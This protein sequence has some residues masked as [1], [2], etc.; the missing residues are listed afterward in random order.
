MH[1]CSRCNALD[2][3]GSKREPVLSCDR[4][5][6]SRARSAVLRKQLSVLSVPASSGTGDGVALSRWHAAAA[7]SRSRTR[8]VV[9]S[10][11]RRT[12]GLQRTLSR[13]DNHWS[14]LSR[15]CNERLDLIRAAGHDSNLVASAVEFTI[16][17][18]LHL[19][20]EAVLRPAEDAASRLELV[21][22]VGQQT[23]A[24]PATVP[25][26]PRRVARRPN[27]STRVAPRRATVARAG[28][29]AGHVVHSGHQNLSPSRAPTVT[30]SYIPHPGVRRASSRSTRWTHRC[31]Y[32]VR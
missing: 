25:H 14:I 12:P 11:T 15:I 18:V 30:A 2:L 22:Q 28:V 5:T 29:R 8:T 23:A 17:P 4:G 24:R 1:A 19:A 31:K 26:A 13:I 7:V 21:L 27:G 3:L 20:V 16:V 6:V 32:G 9:A 10:S